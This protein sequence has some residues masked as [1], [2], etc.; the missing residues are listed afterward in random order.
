MTEKKGKIRKE[1]NK[2]D[3]EMGT[4]LTEA[5]LNYETVKNFGNESI[6]SNKLGG[7]ISNYQARYPL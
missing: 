1:M 4:C 2:Y 6:E 5:L 3:N 7:A